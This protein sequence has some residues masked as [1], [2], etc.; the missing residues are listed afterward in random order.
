MKNFRMLVLI[1]ILA[2]LAFAHRV[3]IF[4][5]VEGDSIIGQGYYNDG[6]PVRNQKVEVF[7]LNGQTLLEIETDSAGYFRFLPRTREDLKIVLYA[8][9]GH[10]A[11]III[12][13]SDLPEPRK[14]QAAKPKSL[15]E[16]VETTPEK[17]EIDAEQLRRIVE[18]VVEEKFN[19]VQELM[20]KQQKSVSLTTVI[21]GIGYIFGI[22][23]LF[24]YFRRKKRQ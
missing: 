4:A 21:G 1:L 11:E 7:R 3:N 22:F 17:S 6:A 8:G 24:F 14:P 10:Q 9:M 19:A 5:Q 18:E 16:K 23:G 15:Q 2:P 20:V 12:K 13:A